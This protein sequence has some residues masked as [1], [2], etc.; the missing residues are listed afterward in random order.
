ML[1][2]SALEK[3]MVLN[4]AWIVLLH[5]LYYRNDNRDTGYDGLNTSINKSHRTG[6]PAKKERWDKVYMTG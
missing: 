1:T 6:L 3:Q 2:L 4:M 5:I